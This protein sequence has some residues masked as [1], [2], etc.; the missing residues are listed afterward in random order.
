MALVFLLVLA[1]AA[2]PPSAAEPGPRIIERAPAVDPAGE[3]DV[4]PIFLSDDEL[5]RAAEADIQAARGLLRRSARS[6][7]SPVTRALALRLLAVN[8]PGTASARICARS[9]R[10]DVDALV[11][12]GAAECLGRLDADVAGAHTPALV[13]ALD[14]GNLDV[15][16]MAGWAL[17]NVGDAPSIADIARRIDHA[18]PRVGK[19]FL[20]YADRMRA[21]LGLVYQAPEV[22]G[23]DA[24]G[25]RLVP[26][27]YVLVSQAHGLDLAA[28]TGWLG[29]YGGVMG[30]YHGA[31]LLSAHGGQAG[32]EAAA[33]GGL[34]G[35]AVGAAAGSAY[36]FSR[37]DSL[38]LAHTVVQLGTA[39]AFAGF[40]A[41]LLSGF[42][43]ASGVAAANLS[44][45]GTLA[46]TA[47]GIA[48]VESKPPTLG[49]LGVG[50][51]AGLT[52]GTASGAVFRGYGLGDGVSIGAALLVGS[53]ASVVGTIATA[54]LDVGLFP[55]AGSTAGAMAGAGAGGVLA[56]IAEP[57]GFTEGTGWTIAASTLAGAGAGAIAGMLLPRDLDPLLSRELELF[58][59]AI[60]ALE[61]Q[62]GALVPAMV[63]AGRF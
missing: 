26:S 54:D 23:R 37:A 17:A 48:L 43:P 7:P 11:R 56:L 25:N 8:D 16:T 29:L 6:N 20:G 24:A 57:N 40:G 41:G 1:A 34:A 35:A 21:R 15:I 49:A 47:A 32:A 61:S 33:L 14:D 18:D 50:M 60:T 53:T 10:T 9:L 46:G 27:G 51:S 45:A 62:S 52:M 5:A 63:L 36:A 22:V 38:P 4:P 58:P 59:P 19:I 3:A 12:R 13:A 55:L 30:W 42:P 39:G 31:F 44:F 28:A 2:P